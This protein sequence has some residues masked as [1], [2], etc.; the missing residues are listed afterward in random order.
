[1][2]KKMVMKNVETSMMLEVLIGGREGK[3]AF[4]RTNPLPRGHTCRPRTV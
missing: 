2:V 1:V 3:A 4:L